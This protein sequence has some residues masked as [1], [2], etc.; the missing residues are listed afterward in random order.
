MAIRN[1]RRQATLPGVA[2]ATSAPIYCDSDDN[3]V[4]IVPAGS[5]STEVQIIDD[6]SVQT[7][8]NKTL[9]SPTISGSIEGD[10]KVLAASQTFTSTT[11]LTTLTGLTGTLVAGKT[12]QFEIEL[13]TTQTTNG[14]LAAALKYTTATLTSIQLSSRQMSASAIAV[15]SST[16]TTDATKFVDNKTAAYLVTQLNGTL[17]VLAGGTVDVQVAQNT[18]NTDTTTIALG[19]YARFTRV[20]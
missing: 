16:V 17:V 4:K 15:A 13:Y 5:G 8:T 12:Y 10:T 6:S 14:G 20:N 2:T 7:L 3:I 11:V 19:S 1:I 9:T 18:S